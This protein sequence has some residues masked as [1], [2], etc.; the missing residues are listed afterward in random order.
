MIGC[1]CQF[2]LLPMLGYLCATYF[3]LEA[4]IGTALITTTASPGGAYSNWWCSVMNGDLALSLAMT[5]VSTLFAGIFMP[6]NLIF[7]TNLAYSSSPNLQISKL[8]VNVGLAILGIAT[9]TTISH[10]R[11]KLR[12]TMNVIGN[13]AGLCLIVFGA[14]FSSRDDPLWD[15]TG[16]FYLAVAMPCCIGLVAAFVLSFINPWLSRP[17]AVSITVETVYQNT[18]LALSICLATFPANLR[19]KV[20]GV[21]LYYSVIQ[22]ILLPLFLTISWKL[23]FTYCPSSESFCRM[24][25][26]DWQPKPEG[27]KR[28]SVV[29]AVSAGV[30][31]IS[32]SFTEQQ[33]DGPASQLNAPAAVELT[34][35]FDPANAS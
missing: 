34:T 20:A 30:E 6:M 23:G 25:C 32:R 5:T 26:D 29:A 11:P 18:G 21:P 22:V 14:V 12:N 31:A 27:T 24:A 33:N 35:S 9:G 15:K 13:I 28:V 16:T 8:L 1:C 3:G 4:P 7:W 10:C 19:G 2:G 17:E